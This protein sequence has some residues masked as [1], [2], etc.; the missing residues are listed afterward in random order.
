MGGPVQ[1]NS[2]AGEAQWFYLKEIEKLDLSEGIF[3]VIQK[4]IQ[5]LAE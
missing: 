3:D 1:A 5:I 4:G 2:D